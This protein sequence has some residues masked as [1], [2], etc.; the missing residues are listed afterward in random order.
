MRVGMGS[1]CMP[2]ALLLHD[3][4]ALQPMGHGC[5][6]TPPCRPCRASSPVFSATYSDPSFTIPT[7]CRPPSERQPLDS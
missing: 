7:L 4:P 5:S 2:V 3:T 1:M 6:A